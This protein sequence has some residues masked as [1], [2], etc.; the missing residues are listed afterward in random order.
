MTIGE[1][2]SPCSFP[3][4]ILHTKKHPLAKVLRVLV[5]GFEPPRF[6]R[7]ILS[8]MRM[9]FRHTSRQPIIARCTND[10]KGTGRIRPGFSEIFCA[11]RGLTG[12]I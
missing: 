8:Q 7:L 6:P 12:F 10:C 9:P 4:V 3:S 2:Y 1:L 11:K 5:K